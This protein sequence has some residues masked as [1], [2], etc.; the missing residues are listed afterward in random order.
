MNSR[1]RHI[2]DVDLHVAEVMIDT[3][4][5]TADIAIAEISGD[6]GNGEQLHLIARRQR[7]QIV[8][9]SRQIDLRVGRN[10]L[11]SAGCENRLS[12]YVVGSRQ[13][14]PARTYLEMELQL[15]A[16]AVM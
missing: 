7:I 10:V 15:P 11:G 9:E 8:L 14:L 6:A 16:S 12:L 2:G 1:G 5:P 13:I 3:R 4:R